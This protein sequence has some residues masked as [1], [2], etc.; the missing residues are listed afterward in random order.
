MQHLRIFRMALFRGRLFIFTVVLLY[1]GF[2]STSEAGAQLQSQPIV[3]GTGGLSVSQENG[4]FDL[5]V[6]ARQHKTPTNK[7]CVTVHGISRQ[8]I[9]SNTIYE[10]ILILENACNQPIKLRLCYFQSTS[11]VNSTVNPYSRRQQTLGIA[12]NAK[13]FRYAYTEEF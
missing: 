10:H 4:R 9:V 1:A 2:E 12:P 7:P 6:T 11:C 13:D 5:S 8:Q 3:G